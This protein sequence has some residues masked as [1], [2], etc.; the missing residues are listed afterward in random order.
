MKSVKIVAWSVAVLVASLAALSFFRGVSI[1]WLFSPTQGNQSRSCSAWFFFVERGGAC[2]WKSG[3]GNGSFEWLPDA[4]VN[5][6]ERSEYPYLF[7][8]NE[9]GIE[10]TVDEDWKFAGFQLTRF[11]SPMFR[12]WSITVPVWPVIP[13]VLVLGAFALRKAYRARRERQRLNRGECVACGYGLHVNS[14]SCPECGS[15]IHAHL[16]APGA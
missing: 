15:H 4:R 8:T 6:Y 7:T 14:S 1:S 12:Q 9:R 2:L 3:P 10:V 13:F 5:L 11:F 16:E